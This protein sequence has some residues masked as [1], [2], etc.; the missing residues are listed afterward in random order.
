[1]PP[2][3]FPAFAAIIPGPMKA[4]RTSTRLPNGRRRTLAPPVAGAPDEATW[5]C[6]VPV[7]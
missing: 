7:T 5:T 4:S 2:A 6:S 1:M 3:S